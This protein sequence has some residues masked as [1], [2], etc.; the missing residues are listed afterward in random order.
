M[1]CPGSVPNVATGL[2]FVEEI[3]PGFDV[4]PTATIAWFLSKSM[5]VGVV[6]GSRP[7]SICPSTCFLWVFRVP[8]DSCRI[9]GSPPFSAH[10]LC[11]EPPE[12]HEKTK[13]ESCLGKS[14]PNAS[15]RLA[16]STWTYCEISIAPPHGV[17]FGAH[18]DS[19]GSI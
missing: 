13:T 15:L 10:Q 9:L 16:Y 1:V 6:V 7:L 19:I 2:A 3:L 14:A 11:L 17:F 8:H 5:V 4:I 18:A 12:A